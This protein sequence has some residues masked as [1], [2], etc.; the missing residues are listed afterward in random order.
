MIGLRSGLKTRLR[1]GLAS[2]I[3]ADEISAGVSVT[4]DGPGSVF[5]PQTTSDFTALGIATP[6]S[7]WLCQE[8]A[9]NLADVTLATTLTATGTLGYSQV[10]TGW[11]RTA[12]RTDE[13]NE[14]FGTTAGSGP[15]PASAS[16]AWLGYI[17]L[18][19]LAAA[20]G[21]VAIAASHSGASGV[22]ATL[23]TTGTLTC[24]CVGVDVT[25]AVDHT[26]AT[27]AR[28]ILLQ[29]NRTAGVVRV[30]TN[31]ET[32]TGTYSAA[33]ADST[34]GFG[35][36]G[37]AAPQ[38]RILWAAAFSGTNAESLSASTLTSLGW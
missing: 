13:E 24:H 23:N 19:S 8:A 20:N 27:V 36:N 26:S 7:I 25:G 3:S 18:P 15:N 6:V 34:K 33:S 10:I 5:V 9:G 12:V 17:V 11:T 35:S 28:A 1:T 16:V 38:M 29:Y 32:I 30:I 4:R 2:G 14:R 31:L 21:R 37:G 22:R